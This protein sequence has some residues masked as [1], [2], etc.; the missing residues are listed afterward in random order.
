M[1]NLTGS[2]SQIAKATKIRNS[3]I[4]KIAGL[5]EEEV[6]KISQFPEDVDFA[7]FAEMVKMVLD[8]VKKSS[9]WIELYGYK[10]FSDADIAEDF[11]MSAEDTDEED[12]EDFKDI[13]GI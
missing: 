2:E 3:F 6:K 1:E 13:W 10:N 9:K 11:I 12:W 8:N 7:V 4:E 5:C